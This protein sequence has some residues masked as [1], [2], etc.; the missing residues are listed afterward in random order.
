[1][2]T[3]VMGDLHPLGGPDIWEGN[4]VSWSLIRA[5]PI[6]LDEDGCPLPTQPF[7]RIDLNLRKLA[8][9]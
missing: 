5:V 9:L 7:P 8:P 1:M 4:P 2:A 6:S 3:I